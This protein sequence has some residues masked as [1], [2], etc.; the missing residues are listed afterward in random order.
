MSIPR[1]ASRTL[2]TAAPQIAVLDFGGQYA[3]LIVKRV[4]HLGVNCIRLPGDATTAAGLRALGLKGLI[5]SGGPDSVYATGA[6]QLDP[7][8]LDLPQPY[9]GICYG[10]QL[11]AKLRGGE[12]RP[13]AA[14]EDG[15]ST[16]HILQAT[17]LFAGLNPTETVWMSHGDT[18]T[19]PPRGCQVTARSDQGLIAALA[20]D[21][22]RCY[23]V[24][25][26]P[27]VNDTPRGMEILRNFVFGLCGCVPDYS[28]EER[29]ATAER[30]IRETIGQDKAL[31]LVSGGVDSCVAATLC[32][33]ALDPAQVY[34]IHVDHG[35]MRE[36]E[37]A[38]IIRRLE[39]L[40]FR[41][42]HLRLVSAAETFA[43][44]SA[45]VTRKVYW[46]VPPDPAVIP[47]AYPLG[48]GFYEIPDYH[49]LPLAQVVRPEEKRIII[50]DT[51]IQIARAQMAELGLTMDN[52]FLVQ[53]TLFTDLI[54]SGSQEVSRRAAKIKT[55]HNV[56]RLV[57]DFRRANRL[58]EPNA[59]LYK[60][61]VRQV[62]REL[63]LGEDLAQRR[64]FPGPGLSIR[65]LCADGPIFTPRY[66]EI[67]AQVQSLVARE[68]GGRLKGYLIPIRSVGVQGDERTY[69][70][71]AV[72]TGLDQLAPD[73]RVD[74]IQVRDVATLL[75]R[76][77]KGPDGVNRVAFLLSAP[78]IPPAYIT[79]ILP[80]RL[81]PDMLA[82]SRR[83][84]ALGEALLEEYDPDHRIA[85]M[86]FVLFPS[87][88]TGTGQRAVAIRGLVTDDFMTGQAALPELHL[89]WTFFYRAACA[90]LALE[91]VGSVVVDV[92]S[93][94]PATTCW[95]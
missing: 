13:E 26:H 9:L 88:F 36:N 50:G 61:D 7:A 44:A 58:V 47:D 53:G 40:G 87:D 62:A 22:T 33:R 18:V 75:T 73:N 89:P 83:I 70:Y 72:L 46:E 14:R 66:D 95:E 8:V 55:H 4:K 84:H 10:M 30:Y 32:L 59:E 60:D 49:T 90:F 34:A 29:I 52:C 91:G 67:A 42:G 54:E 71:L 57:E 35:F 11:L 12:V 85:Q 48:Q 28:L 82:L 25:F 74:W 56:S 78:D 69:S 77:I 21:A 1:P 17:G 3:H 27:E 65:I 63:G 19:Q 43:R 45:V 79:R 64:P 31:I 80:T 15:R 16:L 93:K 81:T 5:A 2:T 86:P 68:S 24:Q 76:R 41:P 37:S 38:E 20:D 23:G 39:A 6:P 51:F 94:P 92:S